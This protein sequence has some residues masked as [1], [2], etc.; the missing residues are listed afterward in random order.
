MSEQSPS[1]NQQLGRL[2]LPQP[3]SDSRIHSELLC[4]HIRQEMQ[5]ADGKL[6]FDRFMEMCLYAP[7]LG[8]YEARS[9]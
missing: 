3:D 7:A 9:R 5:R 6:P 2:E 1:I 8:Y 4:N